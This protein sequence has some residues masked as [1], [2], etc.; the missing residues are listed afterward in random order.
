[1]YEWFFLVVK[2]A[3]VEA[4]PGGIDRY[5]HVRVV[6]N[7]RAAQPPAQTPSTNEP[8]Q[9][10]KQINTA[11]SLGIRS[12]KV[13]DTYLKYYPFLTYLGS[14]HHKVIPLLK[15]KC[16]QSGM[17][18]SHHEEVSLFTHSYFPNLV[19]PKLPTVPYLP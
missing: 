2:V 8:K 11:A 6:L 18:R 9:T 3:G 15:L 12:M 4:T 5:I 16:T 1:M 14:Y 19:F 13:A 10:E 17:E 7:C